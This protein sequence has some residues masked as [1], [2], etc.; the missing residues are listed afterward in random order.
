MPQIGCYSRLRFGERLDAIQQSKH[1]FDFRI[2]E[3]DTDVKKLCEDFHEIR[4]AHH[5]TIQY[6]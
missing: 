1:G 5:G 2:G 3:R 6:A 4:G